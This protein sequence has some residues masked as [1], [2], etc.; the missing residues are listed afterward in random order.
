[1]GQKRIKLVDLAAEEQKKVPR[2]KSAFAKAM[3]DKGEKAQRARPVVKAG[4]GEHGHLADMGVSPEEAEEITKVEEVSREPKDEKATKK[5]KKTKPKKVRSKRYQALRKKVDRTKNYPLEDALPLLL[6]LANSNFDEAVE[7]H[8][9]M[10][11]TGP[12]TE[13]KAPLIHRKIGKVSEGEKKLL[14]A[15]QKNLASVRANEI[16]K[17]VLTS[18]MSPSIKLNL[19]EPQKTV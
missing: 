18:T 11:K 3:V 4:K 6:E 10:K 1:M 14:K 2:G 7:L 5:K 15:L 17:A 12:Q 16:R 9:V 8:L 19:K 13:R